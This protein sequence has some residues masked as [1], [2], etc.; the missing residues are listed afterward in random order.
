MQPHTLEKLFSQVGKEVLLKAIVQ[1][2]PTFVMTCFRLLVGLC[3]D[4]EML[5]CKF[6][7]GLLQPKTDR[8]LG[9]K[10]LC[11][12][13]EAM[14]AKQVWHLSQ[15]RDSLF[16]QVFKAKYFPNC[17]IFEAKSSSGSFVW[18]SILRSRKLI[19]NGSRRRIGDGKSTR[20]F[21]DAWLL[22]MEGGKV[23]SNPCVLALDAIVDMLINHQTGWWNVHLI[24]LCFYPPEVQLI[25]SLPLCTTPRPI[26]CFGQ[27]KNL[28]FILS[29]LDINFFVNP[30]MLR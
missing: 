25:K 4:I 30:K 2:I 8:G 3:Q 24:D 7:W 29:N 20:I 27:W 16:Y 10:D 6:W 19:E 9:F 17:S 1:A 22:N 5:I 15:D 11:K 21:K 26:P 14:L 12:F 13:N 28:V 18:K 23:L